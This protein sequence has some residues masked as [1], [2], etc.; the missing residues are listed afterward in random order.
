VENQLCVVLANQCGHR[1]CQAEARMEAEFGEV[2][3]E[4]R[5]GA[6][7]KSPPPMAA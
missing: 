6:G 1:R 4:A 5:F 3:G 2:S 7:R